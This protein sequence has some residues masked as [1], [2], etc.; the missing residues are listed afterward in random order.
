MS[1]LIFEYRALGPDGP[2]DGR[3]RAESEIALDRDLERQ[4]LTLVHSKVVSGGSTTGG[5]KLNTGDL[6]S[7][8]GQVATVI[9]AGVP[10]VQGIKQLSRRMPRAQTRA[11]IDDIVRELEGGG[12]LSE[13]ME[14][15]SRSFPPVYRASV[16][17]G[18]ISGAMP[19]VL[20]RMASYLEWAR[21][22]RQTTTQALVYPAVLSLAI[23]GL[24]IVLITFVL[25]RIV[26]MFP[27]GPEDL[28]A[29]TRSLLAVS[30]F[31][32]GNWVALVSTIAVG[33]VLA[34]A[35]GKTPAGRLFFSTVLMRV[36]RLGTVMQMLAISKFASTAST[37]QNAG[38]DIYSV[39]NL[40][41]ASSGN[42]VMQGA[43][44][45]VVERVKQGQPLTQ[46]FE[47]EPGMDPMLIQMIGIG[48]QSGDLGTAL[49]QLADYYNK[50]VPRMV[51]WFMSLMEPAILVL[52]AVIVGY[53]LMA[54]LLPVLE[55]Y[56]KL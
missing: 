27:G 48:E 10:M 20:R 49:E 50:E 4:G 8:T 33:L 29:Q 24:V 36:P 18:E 44:A 34:V 25:P 21:S 23:L 35:W 15:H 47:K 13:A 52:A 42:A 31:I 41:S 17:A 45:R 51:K 26:K 12:S 3:L 2:V 9:S 55:M 6:V 56:E 37:L 11:V 46:A 30:S 54:A 5:A 38:C 53:V 7:F 28:P 22:I 1:T 16:Q 19:E 39:L 32:T 43:F 40:A 14:V